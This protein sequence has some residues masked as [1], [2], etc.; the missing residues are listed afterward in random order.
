[1]AGESTQNPAGSESDSNGV[2][3]VNLAGIKRGPGRPRK[4]GQPSGSG[5]TKKSAAARAPV[6]VDSA[7]AEFLADAVITVWESGDELLHTVLLKKIRAAI[8][9]KVD[10]FIELQNAVRLG[11]KDKEL[12]RKALMRIAQK[13]QFLAKFAPEILLLGLFAQYG[14]R[15][16]RVI[17]LV[18]TMTSAAEN[19]PKKVVP[20]SAPIPAADSPAG[21]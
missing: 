18:E 11:T 21:G 5:D 10:E 8:P 16:L 20:A 12:A 4:D 6:Q 19:R 2:P 17:K 3:H 9:D 1:M 14:A 13:Y 7:D 15:Q